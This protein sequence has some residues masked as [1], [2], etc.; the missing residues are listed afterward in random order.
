MANLID[1]DEDG[2]TVK[3]KGLVLRL[4][5]LSIL[6]GSSDVIR[7]NL[8]SALTLTLQTSIGHLVLQQIGLRV[9]ENGNAHSHRESDVVGADLERLLTSALKAGISH[10]VDH[11]VTLRV[12][13]HGYTVH[14]KDN[15]ILKLG[16]E[17]FKLRDDYFIRA[18]V[19]LP[20]ISIDI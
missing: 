3:E 15:S 8:P 7:S 17:I 14:L 9:D 4:H 2:L 10:L 20:S 12:D 5:V 11:E 1:V 19:A 16:H 13:E 18:D 6:L